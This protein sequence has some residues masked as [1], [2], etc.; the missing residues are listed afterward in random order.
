MVKKTIT[1]YLSKL[2]ERWSER[3]RAASPSLKHIEERADS[4]HG[5][6]HHCIIMPFHTDKKSQIH[7]TTEMSFEF[8][9][10]FHKEVYKT[11]QYF[12]QYILTCI[13]F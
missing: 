8:G 1:K 12:P 4:T 6:R 11:Q 7:K 13:G 5:K 9:E 3:A 10:Y 2:K